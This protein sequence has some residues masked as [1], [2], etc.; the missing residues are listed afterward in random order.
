MRLVRAASMNA[1]LAASRCSLTSMPPMSRHT[2][3]LRAWPYAV[4]GS[5]R[6]SSHRSVTLPDAV[7]SAVI[8]GPVRVIQP[9]SSSP[10]GSGRL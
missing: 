1:V 4:T 9:S 2:A 6:A 8:T 5:R 10:H 7:H 3:A